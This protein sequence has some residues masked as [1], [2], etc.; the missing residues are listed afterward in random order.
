[1]HKYVFFGDS[2]TE[3]HRNIDNPDDLGQGFVL[4]LSKLDKKTKFYNRGIGGQRIKDLLNRYRED[5]VALDPD[6]CFIWI[7]VNDAWLPYLLNQYRS[8]DSFFSDYK[9]LITHIKEDL[10]KTKIVLI[11][12]YAIPIGHVS[13]NVH[14]DI[15]IIRKQT[16]EVSSFFNL[17]VIDIKNA[18]E[19][20]L[21]YRPAN[22]LF[23]DGIHPTLKGYEIIT[24][25]IE[26]YIKEYTNDL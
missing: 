10:K 21:R 17:D 9:K 1:M 24:S 19:E 22:Q 16:E 18:I 14:E 2:V 4:N 3:A 25:V 23:H 13:F 20:E 11:K 5:V 6:V 8:I 12:A 26:K 15:E 7:G